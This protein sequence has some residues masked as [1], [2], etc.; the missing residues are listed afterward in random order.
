M[1]SLK[2]KCPWGNIFLQEHFVPNIV[3]FTII[4]I[5][6]KNTLPFLFYIWKLNLSVL[7]M[8]FFIAKEWMVWGENH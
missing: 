1:Q 6:N 4:Y 2:K 5:F 7:K 3:S 8:K